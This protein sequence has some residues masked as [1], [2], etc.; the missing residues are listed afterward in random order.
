[1]SKSRRERIQD[2]LAAEPGDP[3]LGYMLAM[4]YVSQGDDAAAVRTFHD[5]IT[6]TPT[7][8]AAYHQGGRAL[9]RLDR[10]AE[11]REL[12][13]RGIPIAQ[14]QGNEHAAGE[15]MELLQSL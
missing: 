7:Y 1:M 10:S 15:M 3:E 9:Q 14:S 13:Q 8:A 5:V 11:A 4:E 6:H 2:M 12:L